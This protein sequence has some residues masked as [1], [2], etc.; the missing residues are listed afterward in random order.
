[1]NVFMNLSRLCLR[2]LR[3]LL[4]HF[5]KDARGSACRLAKSRRR[6]WWP[7]ITRLRTGLQAGVGNIAQLV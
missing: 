7:I 2:A 1:M 3:A 5:A 6:R 4:G